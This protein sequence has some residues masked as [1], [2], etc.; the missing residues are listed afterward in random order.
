M[1]RFI[2]HFMNLLAIFIFIN[3]ICYEFIIYP[4]FY[5]DYEEISYELRSPN[6]QAHYNKFLLADSHGWRIT[7]QNEDVKDKLEENGIYNMSY[8]S[9]SYGDILVKLKWLLRHNIKIDTMFVTVDDHM[10]TKKTNNS[11]RSLI[12][13]DLESHREAYGIGTVKFY[14]FKLSRF[15]P[16]L[17][18]SNQKLIKEYLIAQIFKRPGDLEEKIVWKDL[19]ESRRNEKIKSKL[20]LFFPGEE[21]RPN[22]KLEKNLEKIIEIAKR[23]KISIMGIKFPIDSIMT[24]RIKRMGAY[25]EVADFAKEKG[26]DSFVDFQEKY[27]NVKYLSNQDHVNKLGAEKVSDDL[28]MKVKN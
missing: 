10:L 21:F 1:K 4:I 17:Y 15:L 8:G 22:K 19:N 3:F 9:D 16:I 12:Y 6:G 28:I 20:E 2:I 27:E 23:N 24:Y 18:P 14:Y 5:K 26:V 13:S 25:D 7:H 11:N